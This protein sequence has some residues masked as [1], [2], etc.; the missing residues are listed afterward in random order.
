[1]REFELLT[2]KDRLKEKEMRRNTITEKKLLH[3]FPLGCD[4]G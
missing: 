2:N 4:I 3:E 1:M